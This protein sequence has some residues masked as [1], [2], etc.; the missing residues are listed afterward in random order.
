M[1]RMATTITIQ[2]NTLARFKELKRELD[3][4]QGGPDH[5]NDSFLT[6]LMDTYEASQEGHYEEDTPD[7]DAIREQLE[8]DA[9]TYDDVQQACRAAIRKELPERVLR[10]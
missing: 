5:T 8:T 6:C 4:V 3:E 9:P 1:P 7:I 2:D 10:E